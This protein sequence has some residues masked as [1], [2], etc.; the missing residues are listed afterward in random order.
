MSVFKLIQNRWLISNKERYCAQYVKLEIRFPNKRPNK[1]C[2]T[3]I[4]DCN[5]VVVSLETQKLKTASHNFAQLLCRAKSILQSNV[6][7]SD[8]PMI[9]HNNFIH[10]STSVLGRRLFLYN[11]QATITP[12]KHNS[13]IHRTKPNSHSLQSLSLQNSPYFQHHSLYNPDVSFG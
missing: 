2:I 6:A 13:I 8:M 10:V 12:S 7:P 3:L 9:P 5:F 1:K 4:V 11:V